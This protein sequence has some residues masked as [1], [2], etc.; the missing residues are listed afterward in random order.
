MTK[1]WLKSCLI[2]INL[3][4]FDSEIRNKCYQVNNM[5]QLFQDIS[6]D[7]L[8]MFSKKSILLVKYIC[9]NNFSDFNSMK[10]IV[11]LHTVFFSIQIIFIKHQPTSA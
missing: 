9:V 3:V 5:K 1:F 6:I 2:N 8:N 7:N 10:L 4:I 11:T